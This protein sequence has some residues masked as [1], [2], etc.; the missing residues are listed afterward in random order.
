MDIQRKVERIKAE[1]E[2]LIRGEGTD[3]DKAAALVDINAFASAV[4]ID[5]QAEKQVDAL[6]D[7]ETL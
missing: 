4:T 3:E 5:H 2:F 1:I 6:V 7:S